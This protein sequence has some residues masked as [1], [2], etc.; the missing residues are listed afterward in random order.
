MTTTRETETLRYIV[1]HET[2]VEP[3]RVVT[4][5]DGE[6]EDAP[7]GDAPRR[8]AS[9]V[10]ERL[11]ALARLAPDAVERSLL[12]P[13]QLAGQ[14]ELALRLLVA[15]VEQ[16]IREQLIAGVAVAFV[17]PPAAGTGTSPRDLRYLASFRVRQ[18]LASPSVSGPMPDADVDAPFA[19]FDPAPLASVAG[20][21]A[22]LVAWSPAMPPAVRA[23]AIAFPRYQLAW[24]PRLTVILDEHSEAAAPPSR[25][26]GVWTLC[27]LDSTTALA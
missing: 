26:A 5:D 23:L 8:I 2:H 10:Y 13:E 1:T 12:L 21:S 24:A 7:A 4:L 14:T 3:P 11:S 20:E 9:A 17:A 27:Q 22:L 25:A 18:P 15:D 16:L 6:G 19:R